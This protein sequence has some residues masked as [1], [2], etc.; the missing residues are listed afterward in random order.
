MAGMDLHW[1]VARMR[2]WIELGDREGLTLRE[3][4]KRAGVSVKTV[5]RWCAAM[6]DL[7]A[8]DP[9]RLLSLAV[10]EPTREPA[11]ELPATPFPPPPDR[12]FLQLLEPVP[13]KPTQIQI[14]LAGDRRRVLVDGAVDV[15]VLARV[16][17][18]VDRC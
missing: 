16:I 11:T 15:D 3:V 5:S 7:Q 8:N 14:L 9:F 1:R 13:T 17:E 18:A 4:A 2:K 10:G 6:R 12:A